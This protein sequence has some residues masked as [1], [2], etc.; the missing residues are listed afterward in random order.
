MTSIHHILV[1][2]ISLS[3][4]L[5]E[6]L[7]QAKRRVQMYTRK[8]RR[9]LKDQTIKDSFMFEAVMTDGDNCKELLEMVLGRRL[10][11][12]SVSKEHSIDN[13]PDYKASR[14]DIFASDEEGTRYNIEMQVATE[15]TELRSRYYHSQMDM[16]ILL[17]GTDYE[18]L[19]ESYVI[20]ICDYDPLG[21]NKYIYTMNTHCEELPELKY[22]DGVHTIF[23]STKGDNT[24]EVPEEIIKFL[25][26]V[27]AGLK[28][29]EQDFGSDFVTKLQRSVKW[30]KRSRS[31]EREY[32][33][34]DEIK[35]KEREEGRCDIIVQLLQKM[36][37]A[38]KVA[39]LLDIPI[40]DI[41]RIAK[42]N[43]IDV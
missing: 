14:L 26:Y 33:V 10:T 42:S 23:L 18:Y 22:R 27:S 40:E 1:F 3:A 5:H 37:D 25:R 6:I 16:D 12:I 24:T 13:N 39:E 34:L 38:N 43:K 11:E 17:A 29:S 31:K 21:Y 2:E 7:Q 36:H 15:H 4:S 41:E 35:K 30:I 28:E 9:T 19:P 20:F 8:T 32:M